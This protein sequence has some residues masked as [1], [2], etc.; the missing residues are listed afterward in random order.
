MSYQF[1]GVCVMKRQFLNLWVLACA[2]AFVGC[3][4]EKESFSCDES[5]VAHCTNL[6]HYLKCENGEV[7]LIECALNY[8]CE[9]RDGG[10]VGCFDADGKTIDENNKTSTCTHETPICLDE[11]RLE[12]CS[13]GQSSV[14][15]CPYGCENGTCQDNPASL[16]CE[17]EGDVRC[18]PFNALLVQT[19]TNSLWTDAQSLCEEGC[20]NGACKQSCVKTC[21]DENTV[22][23]ACEDKEAYGVSC[24]AGCRDGDCIDIAVPDYGTSCSAAS[25]PDRCI[26]PILAYCSQSKVSEVFCT[27]TSSCQISTKLDGYGDCV[28]TC[29]TAGDV[30]H[31]CEYD[32]EYGGYY[33]MKSVCENVNG[34]LYQFNS[35]I[36]YCYTGCNA[37]KTGC[38]LENENTSCDSSTAK[39]QC[40]ADLSY[41]I[42]CDED[43]GIWTGDICAEGTQC[44]LD[45]EG[46]VD[47]IEPCNAADVG[48][49]KRAC[50][51]LYYYGSEYVYSF[52]YV[53]KQRQEGVYGYVLQEQDYYT[54]CSSL[55]C[56]ENGECLKLSDE[57]N[58]ECSSTYASRCE[59]S[60]A[61]FCSLEEGQTTGV[62]GAVDCKVQSG[63][64]FTCGIVDGVISCIRPCTTEG[65]TQSG[66]TL[67][68]DYTYASVGYR[69]EQNGNN[70]LVWTQQEVNHPCSDECNEDYTACAQV[71]DDEYQTCDASFVERCDGD[72]A[73]YC[74]ESGRINTLSCN[75]YSRLCRKIDDVAHCLKPCN[76]EGKKTTTCEYATG[77]TYASTCTRLDDGQFVEIIDSSSEIECANGCNSTLTGC[78]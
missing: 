8:F 39:A 9:E 31:R 76:V 77:M 61:I 38:A 26:G 24:V 19:C 72:V 3:S 18:S 15:P 30:V 43:N 65:D 66:C 41:T 40:A 33:V 70:G 36:D 68:E 14:S 56:D 63:E 4:E 67:T 69:C 34:T 16:K 25:Y 23:I 49:T 42:Y 53:C 62:V 12:T 78:K 59:G 45:S 7:R 73:V 71:V 27:G 22:N 10:E 6:T 2:V 55:K 54:F 29:E 51:S 46:N 58:Q 50:E 1:K 75:D 52:S 13:D 17:T 44:M 64:D 20:E 74:N 35:A 28:K 32:A 5:Y 21:T 11:T 60:V 57:E 37:D 48:K 47:C